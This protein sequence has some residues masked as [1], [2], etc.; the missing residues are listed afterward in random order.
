MSKVFKALGHPTRTRIL[1]ALGQYPKTY[2][3]LVRDIGLDPQVYAGTFNHHL[4][5]LME[6]SLVEKSKNRSEYR[7]TSI[8][9]TVLDFAGK[10]TD[11]YIKKEREVDTQ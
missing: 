9:K 2:S 1:E 8:G 10:T 3:N 7:L 5:V 6:A 11:L 4:K